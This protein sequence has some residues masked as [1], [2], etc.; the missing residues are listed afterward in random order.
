MLLVCG[1]VFCCCG[2]VAYLCFRPVALGSREYVPRLD[3]PV[4]RDREVAHVALSLFETFGEF[5]LLVEGEQVV[6]LL[7]VVD[8]HVCRR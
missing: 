1:L 6:A 3:A 5:V 8:G 2:L 4:G 7:L